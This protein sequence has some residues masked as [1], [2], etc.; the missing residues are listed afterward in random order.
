MSKKRRNS[1][2]THGNHKEHEEEQRAP[3]RDHLVA[4]E[5]LRGV[6]SRELVECAVERCDDRTARAE[7]RHHERDA[8]DAEEDVEQ[9]SL[10]RYGVDV[11]V[12]DCRR[13][14]CDEVKPFHQNEVFVVLLG[15][16]CCRCRRTFR[17]FVALLWHLLMKTVHV[18]R[19]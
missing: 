11:P 6:P 14:S 2:K 17:H 8:D 5:S 1:I 18:S 16:V 3:H 7:Q 15:D 12:S 13:A 9:F 19:V 4:N 10:V